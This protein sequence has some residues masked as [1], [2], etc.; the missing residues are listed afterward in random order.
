MIG[1]RRLGSALRAGRL[2]ATI[3]RQSGVITASAARGAIALA[4]DPGALPAGPTRIAALHARAD[5]TR[6]ALAGADQ[7]LDY[8]A[9][10]ERLNR[11]ASAL[12]ALGVGPGD[13]VALVLANRPEGI[14]IPWAASRL[15]AIVVPLSWRARPAELAHAFAHSSTRL[16]IHEPSLADVVAEG[17]RGLTPAPRTIA[18][19]PELDLLIARGDPRPP[20]TAGAGDGGLIVYTSGTT[21]RPKG[22]RRSLGTAFFTPLLD[23]VARVGFTRDDRQ[24]VVCPLYHSAPPAIASITLG[25]GGAVHVAPSADPEEILATIARERITGMFVVP[26]LLQRLLALPDAARARHDPTSL[27]WILSGAAP[28]PTDVARR[29][30]AS[31]GPILWNFY[32]ATETG[33]VTLAGPGEHGARPGTIGRA[34]AD[35]DVRLLDEHGHDV[36]PGE[37]GALA[38]KS[39]MLADGYHADAD[40]TRAATTAGY[41]T[42]GDLARR[43]VDGFLY[44]AGRAHDLVISGGVNVY[45]LE[46]ENR[47]HE[48]PDVFEAAVVGVPDPDWGEALHAFVVARPGRP[49][50]EPDAL[51]AFCRETL[52]SYKVPK[53]VSFLDALPRNPTGKV[54]KRELTVPVV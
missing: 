42:V 40:A 45:P 34:L 14:A 4:R 49:R 53:R 8:A 7:R 26:T 39:G 21:G 5:G 33:L 35:V 25:L 19:G 23:L 48:H 20:H 13:R 47:L 12:A 52:A 27:R 9:L 10:D 46:I 41:F 18:L 22:A 11:I 38:V 1:G 29:T 36:A 54:L 24:L 15:G 28:L 32:G 2:L 17:A 44:L 51:R 43:D 31:F 50:P 16:V 6:L 30:E 37:V 3:A